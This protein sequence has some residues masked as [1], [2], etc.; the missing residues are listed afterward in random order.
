[1]SG[2]RL[3]LHVLHVLTTSTRLP[4]SQTVT[5]QRTSFYFLPSLL[6][7]ETRT[8]DS[9]S[10]ESRGTR[11]KESNMC[12][13]VSRLS[14]SSKHGPRKLTWASFSGVARDTDPGVDTCVRVPRESSLTRLEPKAT[15]GEL[16]FACE[17]TGVSTGGRGRGSP[18]FFQCGPRSP[19]RVYE[20]YSRKCL[21]LF[22]TDVR[23]VHDEQMTMILWQRK[24]R[25]S[26]RERSKMNHANLQP[27]YFFADV[28]FF[29]LN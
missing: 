26:K 12:A 18:L 25:K 2:P 13:F 27:S 19:R 9:F 29:F 23:H 16:W 1:M 8:N 21:D 15:E 20:F 14:L 3:C 17:G 10:G 22:T 6:L 24:K 5:D 7:R 28:M 4:G 11:T